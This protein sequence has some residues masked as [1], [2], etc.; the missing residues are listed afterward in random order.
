VLACL[1]SR[2]VIL[3]STVLSPT[4]ASGSAQRSPPILPMS[5]QRNSPAA[6]DHDR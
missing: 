5:H 3:P 2:Q 1:R 4:F 6:H